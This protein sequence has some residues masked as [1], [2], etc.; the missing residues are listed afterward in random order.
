MKLGLKAVLVGT[1]V[2]FGMQFILSALFR[3]YAQ[4]IAKAGTESLV[5]G[6]SLSILLLG[7]VLGTF[8]V[9]GLIIG[10]MGERLSLGVPVIVALTV[11]VLSSL[12]SLGLGLRDFVFLVTYEQ[13]AAWFSNVMT[14]ALAVLAIL[15]GSLIGERIQTPTAEE[16]LARW[17]VVIALALILVGPFYFLIPFGLPWYIAIIATLAILVLVGVG[18]FLFTQGPTVEQDMSEISISPERRRGG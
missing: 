10:L 12:V 8:F 18:Y 9:G 6:Q 14:I 5:A 4:T 11:V 1:G 3:V 2:I 13:E 7:V 16:Q 15:G 17:V